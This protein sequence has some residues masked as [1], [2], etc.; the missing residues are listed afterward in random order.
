MWTLNYIGLYAQYAAVGIVT[1][2]TGITYNFCIYYY[3]GSSNLCLNAK[4]LIFLP[5]SFKIF[6]ALLTDNIHPFGSRR[7]LYIIFGWVITLIILLMLACFA[8]KM[9]AEI[10]V[11]CLIL[12]QAFI[13]IA[14]VPSDG[15]CIELDQKENCERKGQIFATAQR[16]RFTFT[17]LVGLIQTF[18]VNGSSTNNPDCD[19]SWDECWKWGLSVNQYYGLIF[20][21]VL[22][23]F[24]PMC[25]LKEPENNIKKYNTNE[26]LEK[27]WSTLQNL[28]TFYLVIY[29]IGIG[30]FTSFSSRVSIYMQYYIIKLSNLQTGVDTIS[31]NIALVCGIW[32][33]QKYLINKNWRITSYGTTILISLFGLLWLPAFYNLL[34]LRNPWYTIFIDIDQ[35]F[36]IGLGQI[37]LYMTTIE[38]AYPGLEATTYEIL[39]SLANSVATIKGIL[40]T[41]L[42]FAV[43]ANGC[44]GSSSGS[45]SGSETTCPPNTVDLSSVEAYENT[46]GPEKF[47]NY[48]FL[49]I[50]ISLV[51]CFLFTQYL[52]KSK[53]ECIEWKNKGNEIGKSNLRAKFIL[54]IFT[55]LILYGIIGAILLLNSTTACLQFVGGNGC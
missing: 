55:I 17:I 15:F 1:G 50:G 44:V 18:L 39:M 40:S 48:T 43:D 19:I 51:F 35:T 4:S 42:L 6:F 13:M 8:D 3:N 45:S 34:G 37:L 16:I 11:I 9:T 31:K 29:I 32:I 38:L 25:Y 5:W 36:V 22:I 24:I 7:K 12:T 41:Q 23:L 30:C 20:I 54:I 21:L 2:S 14:D 49:I 46:N 26:F 52:P 28:T 47:S 10:W 53:E 27:I 33:F